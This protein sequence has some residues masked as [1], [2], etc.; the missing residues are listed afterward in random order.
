MA[1][2]VC[3]KES[4][5]GPIEWTVAVLER[6]TGLHAFLRMGFH[7]QKC[8]NLPAGVP[9][10]FESDFAHSSRTDQLWGPGQVTHSSKSR[11]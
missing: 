4:S 7:A 3:S 8:Q 9:L 2:N 11:R 10:L 5:L 6:G 1:Q